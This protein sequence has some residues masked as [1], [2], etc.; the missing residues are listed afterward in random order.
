MPYDHIADHLFMPTKRKVIAIID[1]GV[2]HRPRSEITDS[3]LKRVF[4][5]PAGPTHRQYEALRAYFVEELPSAE[6]ATR[7]GYTPRSFRVLCHEFRQNPHRAFFPSG[8]KL[9][10]RSSSARRGSLAKPAAWRMRAT[11]AGLKRPSSS[12]SSRLMSPGPIRQIKRV[13]QIIE[14]VKRKRR[15]AACEA[16]HGSIQP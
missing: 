6:A 9:W 4:L 2:S 7:F 5:E 12:C 14:E 13:C 11:A 3:G 15:I 8:L 1:D 16:I 10:G